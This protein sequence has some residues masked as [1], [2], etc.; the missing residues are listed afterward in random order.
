M[1]GA[2]G[3]MWLSSE[4]YV[5]IAFH[6]RGRD[7]HPGQVA[8][9]NSRHE[10]N[11]TGIPELPKIAPALGAEKIFRSYFVSIL[12]VFCT[13]IPGASRG[14]SFR[15]VCLHLVEFQLHFVSILF[16]L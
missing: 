15:H 1:G 6:T 8:V 16:A 9:P 3:Q 10:A 12:F 13:K 14:Q 4:R 7:T 5:S 2:F 11:V